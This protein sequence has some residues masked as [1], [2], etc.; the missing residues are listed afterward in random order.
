[1]SRSNFE[2]LEVYRLSET[3][4]DHVWELVHEW[5]PFAKSSTENQ[6]VRSVDSIGANIAEGVGRKKTGANRYHV[7]IARGS[8]YETK[9]WLRRAYQRD[10]L[11]DE[12]VAE[13][14]PLLDELAPR[15]NAYLNSIG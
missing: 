3:V 8:L 1:M 2:K 5:P 11:T 10:L 4:A 12:Q 13:L 6:L 14:K 7:R 9:Y 15:L